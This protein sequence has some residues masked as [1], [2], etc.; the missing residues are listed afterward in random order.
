MAIKINVGILK[1]GTQIIDFVTDAREIGLEEGLIKNEIFV[2]VDA[3][4]AAHQIDLD[5]KVN[6]TFKL[7]C[8]RC[9]EM[10]EVNFENKFEL[11]YVQ[12]SGVED[13]LNR[14]YIKP[15][16]PFMRSIDITDDVR[17]FIL[18]AIPMK[19]LPVENSD[20]RCSWCG[21]TKDYWR[22]LIVDE[23]QLNK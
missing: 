12:K 18:L 7:A 11:V 22:D 5:V 23:D 1:E 8:D 17:D 21:K 3:F 16:T 9:L 14:D 2:S 6:G 20:G 15:Y 13:E 19:K 4:K 10:Y